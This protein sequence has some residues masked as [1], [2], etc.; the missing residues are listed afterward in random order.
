M[1]R[2]A[3]TLIMPS[4]CRL[5]AGGAVTAAMPWSFPEIGNGLDLHQHLLLGECRLHC[6]TR[7]RI[8]RE[9]LRELLVHHLEVPDVREID[10][11]LED[12][13]HRGATLAQYG[14]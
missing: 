2:P 12:V 3:A 7:R 9:G 11:A 14:L 10:I 6:G 13:G 8:G 5:I 4:V 1:E